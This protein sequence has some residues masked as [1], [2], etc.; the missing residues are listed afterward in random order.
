MKINHLFI[1][2]LMAVVAT[3]AFKARGQSDVGI[4]PQPD[5]SLVVILP[6]SEVKAC[7]DQGGC[8]IMSMQ[9]LDEFIKKNRKH[10]CQGVDL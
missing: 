10:I 3:F 2:L 7:A 6:A 9:Q 1:A 5:G 8:R 4:L